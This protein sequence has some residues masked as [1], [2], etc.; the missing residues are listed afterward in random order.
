MTDEGGAYV[1]MDKHFDAH[2]SIKHHGKWKF[3]R[4]GVHN[5]TAESVNALLERAKVG[6]YH[7]LSKLHMQR[8][9]NEVTFRW[10]HRQAVEKTAKSGEVKV[11]M[12]Q[13]P[14]EAMIASLMSVAVGRQVRRSN[15]GGIVPVLR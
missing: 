13:M 6:V 14:F 2:S 3:A 8:H 7:W 15:N 4:D 1:G 10:N 11:T 5:N 9:V 12:Q